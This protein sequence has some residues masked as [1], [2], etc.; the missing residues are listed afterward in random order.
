M[1]LLISALQI[2]SVE[3]IKRFKIQIL[4]I[5]ATYILQRLFYSHPLDYVIFGIQ[6]LRFNELADLL[7]YK[8]LIFEPKNGVI[9]KLLYDHKLLER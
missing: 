4:V 9:N 1:I 7:T 6:N 8:Y 3:L 2:L 5:Y